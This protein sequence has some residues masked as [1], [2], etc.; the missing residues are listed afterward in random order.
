ME[1]LTMDYQVFLCGL[2]GLCDELEREISSIILDREP[3]V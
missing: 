3:L 2:A 1:R